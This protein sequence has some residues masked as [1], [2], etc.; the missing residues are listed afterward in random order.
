MEVPQLLTLPLDFL[1]ERLEYSSLTGELRWRRRSSAR[2]NWNARCAGKVA[3]A[4]D[5]DGYLRITL[6][7]LGQRRHFRAHR[8]AFA[9]AH[10]RWPDTEIDHKNWDRSDNRL[11]NLREATTAQNR[12]NAK[13]RVDN[14]SGHAG[15]FRKGPR[16]QARIGV[17]GRYE[18]VGCFAS[19]EDAGRAYVAAKAQL[20]P[21]ATVGG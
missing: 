14:T 17:N 19:A 4:V 18:Y 8:L 16:W 7:Y 15:V 21:F 1:H 6:T 10:N 13:K 5:G 2:W 3:G 11:V 12:Q 20:H 9:L